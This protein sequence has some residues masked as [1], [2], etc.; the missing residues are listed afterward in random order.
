MTVLGID[1][2]VRNFAYCVRGTYGPRVIEIIDLL[3]DFNAKFDKKKTFNTLNYDDMHVLI[4]IILTDYFNVHFM[5]QYNVTS[6]RIESMPPKSKKKIWLLCHLI[7]HVLRR[8]VQDTKLVHG[9]L[10]YTSQYKM[11]PVKLNTYK[12]RK[13]YSESIFVDYMERNH[14]RY[15]A[16]GKKLDDAAD[17]FLLTFV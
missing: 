1:V 5:H 4:D 17:A 3:Q 6:I 15:E 11:M 7:F 14:I 2:G 16:L 8:V 12:K 10:K 13:K 9:K